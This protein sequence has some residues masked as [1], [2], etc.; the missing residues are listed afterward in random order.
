MNLRVDVLTVVAI[1]F[2]VGTVVTG[3]LQAYLV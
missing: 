1:I 2:A 3:A